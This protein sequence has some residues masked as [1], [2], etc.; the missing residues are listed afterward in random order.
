M[1]N[2]RVCIYTIFD[3]C[4]YVCMYI[5]QLK[6]RGALQLVLL[7]IQRNG[8]L[9]HAGNLQEILLASLASQWLPSEI[10]NVANINALSYTLCFPMAYIYPQ[11]GALLQPTT[12]HRKILVI[13]VVS[14]K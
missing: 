2:C 8:I 10:R 1:F 6:R 13:I 4:M 9:D 7:R 5:G 11:F 12:Y 14:Q 3:V